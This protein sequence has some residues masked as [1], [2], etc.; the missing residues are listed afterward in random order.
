MKD[1]KTIIENRDILNE[2]IQRIN[3]KL[4]SI[5]DNAKTWDELSKEDKAI[6][7]KLCGLKYHYIDQ[8]KGLNFVLNEDDNLDNYKWSP[9]I[10]TLDEKLFAD[11]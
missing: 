3:F 9:N 10:E 7:G 6:S 2:A 8:V 4:R 1:L 5:R 11:I